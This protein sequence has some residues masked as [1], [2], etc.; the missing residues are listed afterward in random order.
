MAS[1]SSSVD[2]SA[3]GSPVALD[4]G[5]AKLAIAESEGSYTVAAQY[6]GDA[7]YAATL[8][9]DET[10][11]SLTVNPVATSTDVAP[12]T[13]MVA[14]GQSATF[15]ATVTSLDGTP[16]DGSV[17][18]L[19]NGSD[20]GSAV[21]LDNG[22]AQLSISE[23]SGSYSITAEYT[24]DGADFASSPVSAAATLVVATP[25]DTS[26]ALQSSEDPAK[27][28]DS[29]TFTA[30]VSPESGN[31]TPT[32]TVQFSID[33]SPF[34]NSVSLTDGIA[35]ITTT[36]LAVGSH[37]VTTAYTSDNGLFNPSS[38]TLSGG[39]VVN[40]ADV[41]V[42]LTVDHSTSTVGQTVTFTVTL[43]ALTS[44]LATPTGTVTLSEGATNLGSATL[45]NGQA[46]IMTAALPV[47]DDAIT[48]SYSG[49]GDFNQNT[50]AAIADTITPVLVATSIASVSPSPRATPVSSIDVT[51]NVPINA[52]GLMPGAVTLTDDGNDVDISGVSLTLVAGTTATYAI[53]DLSGLTAA[54]GAYTLTVDA[55]DIEDQ[56]GVAGTGPPL[57]TSWNVLATPTI[58][59]ATPADIVYGTPLS[60]T[61]LD[62]T[63]NVPGSFTYSPA[64][65]TI[66][67][68]GD[69]QT[70]SVSFVPTD[71]A[72]YADATGT[73][74][75][76]VLQAIPTITWATPADIVYGTPLSTTQLDA[77]AN[78][79]GTFT[80][81]PASSTILN[82]G[83]GQTL[84]VSFAPTDSFDF[85][86][87]TAQ[88]TL[89]VQLATPRFSGLSTSQTIFAGTGSINLAGTLASNT[90][91][92]PPG[93]V[94]I[95]ID[96]L[97]QT[98]AVQANGTFSATF[99]TLSIPASTTPYTITYAYAANADFRSATDN[100]TTLSVLAATMTAVT[101]NP[102]NTPVPNIYVTFNDSIVTTTLTSA[103]LSLT[104]NGG[105]NLITGSVA[106]T[107]VTA[108]SYLIGGL[109]A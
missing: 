53:G 95:T 65:G 78:V 34:G 40:K 31:V 4:G 60:A 3:F 106:L 18:F 1:S 47:G 44:G 88:T 93:D 104:D 51:F 107:P 26:T 25:V 99:N 17:Q 35:T 14:Y 61:Q 63:A 71:T 5:T 28:G 21:L 98:A 2:G 80:Y 11:A 59:W 54:L 64:A 109:S 102:R 16:P 49:D 32:G 85:I 105:A 70:L 108:D 100:S 8:P 36:S 10:T 68:A 57:A 38:A 97:T 6:T 77:T 39:Q 55:T 29:L 46:T 75:I 43:E 7:N 87:A 89:N 67:G 41:T 92:V 74:T 24:G 52:S 62:A 91:A 20:Y 56:N 9:A 37:T 84:S 79:P 90:S 83:D 81:T 58:T 15:T 33:G 42:G 72:D 22:E 23:P 86:T 48:A 12:G 96:G 27:L 76:N 66:L 50:S 82:A 101:P 45:S 103:D 69:D 30:T 19:V 73:V 13:A 94:S